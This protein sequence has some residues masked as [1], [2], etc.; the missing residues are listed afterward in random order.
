MA[1]R[2]N[3]KDLAGERDR[4]RKTKRQQ[5]TE[6]EGGRQGGREG[7]RERGQRGE[8]NK[9]FSS[10]T[11]FSIVDGSQES[12]DSSES[13]MRDIVSRR[14]LVELA[15]TQANEIGILR[16]EVERLRMK[17]FPALVQVENLF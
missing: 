16:Q 6:R 12:E 9:T 11:C 8:R 5:Q 2:Q 10:L 7:G 17:T 13:R 15:K 3:I 4:E 14:K 1:E